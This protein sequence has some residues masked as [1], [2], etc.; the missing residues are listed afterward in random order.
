MPEY[1]CNML[2]QRGSVLFPAD[3]VADDLEAALRY[4]FEVLR[5]SNQHASLSTRVYALEVW[6]GTSKLFTR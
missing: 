3:I 4:A 1:R 2:D 5:T 6:A